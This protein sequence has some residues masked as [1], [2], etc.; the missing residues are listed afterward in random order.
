MAGEHFRDLDPTVQLANKYT[1]IPQEDR[2]TVL[3]G[4]MLAS[5]HAPTADE[6]Y[7]ARQLGGGAEMAI[8]NR[9][10]ALADAYA[11][12]IDKSFDYTRMRDNDPQ[13]EEKRRNFYTM[14]RTLSAT[15]IGKG[16]TEILRRDPKSTPPQPQ[17]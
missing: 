1:A 13:T 8:E 16:V 5:R 6:L 9:Y 10:G 2:T 11:H 7:R 12:L 15:Q 14:I 17:K 4:L 3:A